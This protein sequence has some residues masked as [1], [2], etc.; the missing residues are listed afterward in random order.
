ML[1]NRRINF[2]D[3]ADGN[4]DEFGEAAVGVYANDFY[5]LANVR[6][7]HAAGAAV[8]A[9][10]VHFG[11]DEIAGLDGGDFR[12][13]FCD[14]AAEFVAEGHRRMNARRGPAV[15]AV[16]VEVRA[17]DGRGAHADQNFDGAR[18]WNGNGFE[19]RSALGT[20]L[21]QSFHRG[22]WHRV[23]AEVQQPA[24]FASLA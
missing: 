21:A 3:V 16:N 22:C 23:Q 17:A 15:P 20:H 12:A 8:A 6:L 11:A 4:D 13:D 1:G 7:A 5:I 24:K 19:L 2:P 10:D 14:V 9:I 18:R